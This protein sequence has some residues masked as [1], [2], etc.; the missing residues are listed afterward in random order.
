MYRAPSPVAPSSYA[1]ATR[2]RSPASKPL[3][4]RPAPSRA[5]VSRDPRSRTS[6][7]PAVSARKAPPA[8]DKPLQQPPWAT[9]APTQTRP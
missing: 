1:G 2:P 7:A 9:K 3:S 8:T 6:T 4:S 5:T